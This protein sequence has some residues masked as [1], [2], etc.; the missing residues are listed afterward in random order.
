M[1][2]HYDVI[3]ENSDTTTRPWQRLAISDNL[4]LY[5]TIYLHSTLFMLYLWCQDDLIYCLINY[6]IVNSLLFTFLYIHLEGRSL[7]W[8]MTEKRPRVLKYIFYY[9]IVMIVCNYVYQGFGNVTSLWRHIRKQRYY[10]APL[11]T[12]WRNRHLNSHEWWPILTDERIRY[13]IRFKSH[14][15]RWLYFLSLFCLSLFCLFSLWL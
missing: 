8:E 1:W 6:Y 14:C 3:L 11:T 5:L 13:S 12:K 9:V 7:R 15:I 10:Y 2:R 4:K